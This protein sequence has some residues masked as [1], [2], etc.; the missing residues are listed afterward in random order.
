MISSSFEPG[1]LEEMIDLVA[2][3]EA[4][5]ELVLEIIQRLRS[6]VGGKEA[7][8][9]AVLAAEASIWNW[10][11]G[12]GEM[13]WS[14]SLTSMLGYTEA[15]LQP[16]VSAFNALLH[17]DDTRTLWESINAHL[18]GE[19]PL[20]ELEI[21]LRH[22]NGSYCWVISRGKTIRDAQQNPVLIAG[23]HLDI[24][25]HKRFQEDARDIDEATEPLV[26]EE[27][28][29]SEVHCK[30]CGSAEVTRSRWQRR[31][32]VLGMFLLR[33]LR[34]QTCG[35]RFYRPIWMRTACD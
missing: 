8:E 2:R 35:H 19:T 30:K 3:H 20:H 6:Q 33:A 12:T 10:K 24:T 28:F 16:S 11:P 17:A 25:A 18:R 32:W 4:S 15:E 22:K 9:I 34:C 27:A 13:S 21:R 7:W 14:T 1:S 5:D 26:L 31:D 23:L 29:A